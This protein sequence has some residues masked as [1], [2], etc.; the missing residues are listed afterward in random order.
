MWRPPTCICKRTHLSAPSS[1]PAPAGA[2]APG[3]TSAAEFAP[4]VEG[5]ARRRPATGRQAIDWVQLCRQSKPLVAAINGRVDRR[6]PDD[7][8]AVRPD[9]RRRG[10]QAVVPLREDGPRARAGV[11]ALPRRP[12]RLRR[13]LVAGPQRRHR[14]RRGGRTLGLVD[15]VVPRRS[16]LLDEAMA[17]AAELAG[18]PADPAADDQGAAVGQ[19]RPRPTSPRCSGGRSRP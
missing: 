6:R 1:S 17:V 15:R 9:H 10:R 11:V 18:Q 13:R 5:D 7:G 3:P 4:G 14:P 2:S 12:L 16:A 8:A 19:R